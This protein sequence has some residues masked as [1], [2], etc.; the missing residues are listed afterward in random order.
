LPSTPSSGLPEPP[1]RRSRWTSFV[2]GIVAA[3][4]VAA[5]AA[6]ALAIR[7]TDGGGDA[8]R[9]GPVASP[10]APDEGEAAPDFALPTLD[11]ET[12]RLSDLRGRP[13]VLNFWASWCN[14]CRKEFPL[15]AA[16]LD[17][18]SAADL[19]VVGVTYR[20]IESDSRTFVDEFGATWPQ[21]VDED[22]EVARAFGVR[23]IPQTFFIDGNGTIAGRVFGFSSAHALE[24]PLAKILDA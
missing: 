14:P 10:E 12:I 1:W 8:T 18:H 21:A 7:D 23:A 3:L 6:W 4:V 20:D 15:L 13:V 24:A 9:P 19:A 17:K 11:G 2:V 5:I 22:G 16:A